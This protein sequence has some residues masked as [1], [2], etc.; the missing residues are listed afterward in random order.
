MNY[1]CFIQSST[2]S[3]LALSLSLKSNSRISF[4]C[5]ISSF[6]C[7]LCFSIATEIASFLWSLLLGASTLSRLAYIKPRKI[8]LRYHLTQ[9]KVWIITRVWIVS[10]LKNGIHRW[11]KTLRE[12]N[13]IDGWIIFKFVATGIYTI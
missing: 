10:I 13:I 11:N 3:S 9:N 4:I 6:I 8:S 12:K 2:S 5:C 7:Y 1:S